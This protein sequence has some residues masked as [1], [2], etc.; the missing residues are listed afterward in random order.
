MVAWST[1]MYQKDQSLTI[2]QKGELLLLLLNH[3]QKSHIEKK[4]IEIRKL[5]KQYS[6][7][8]DDGIF[9][10]SF[11]VEKN[12]LS[13]AQRRVKMAEIKR[14][15]QEVEI[16][17]FS[18]FSYEESRLSLFELWLHLFMFRLNLIPLGIEPMVGV[19]EFVH[20]YYL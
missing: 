13:L 3:F 7:A 12:E 8:N 18:L 20:D 5:E 16:R 1:I 4:T 6:T 2:C 10:E 19:L 11:N 17:Q 15:K 14:R 9:K